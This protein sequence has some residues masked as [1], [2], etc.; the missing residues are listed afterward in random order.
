MALKE[1]I[2]ISETGFIFDP[3]TGDS[4]TLNQI[5]REIISLMDKGLNDKEINAAILDK[6]DVDE[7]TFEQNYYDFKAML[8]YFKLI[9][10]S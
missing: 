4:Y 2:A 10:E 5:A 3:N 1:N 7:I 6:Y 8:N 9:H